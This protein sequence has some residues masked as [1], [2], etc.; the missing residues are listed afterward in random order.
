MGAH[1]HT[2]C[3]ALT[4]AAMILDPFRF[5]F[6]AKDLWLRVLDPIVAPVFL[7]SVG[8]NSGRPF[9]RRFVAQAFS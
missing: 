3:F 9:S 7:V 1:D 4:V 5:Y 6:L 2:T 8:F